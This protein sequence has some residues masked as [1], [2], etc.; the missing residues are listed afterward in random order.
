M[1]KLWRHKNGVWYVL[2]GPRLKRRI[3]TGSRSRSEA[4]TFFAQF[5]AGSQ[6]PALESPT[7]GQILKGYRDDHGRGL[8]GQDGLK[9]GVA[10]LDKRLGKLR[11]DHLTPTVIKRYALERGA[12]AGTI[13][14]EIGVLRA[15]LGWAERHKL[16][17]RRP[18]IL[19]PV[20]TPKPRER[21]LSKDEARRLIAACHDQHIRLFVVLALATCARSGAIIEAQWSQIDWGR[22][23]MDLGDGHGN[24]RRAVVPLN[25]EAFEALTDAKKL[26]CSP[27]I[28]E[29]HGRPIA[30]VKKGFAAACKRAGIVGATPHILRHTGASWMVGAGIPIAEVARMLGDSERTVER[31]YAKFS[32]N[33]LKNAANS[34]Q[35]G[36]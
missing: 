14:R 30:S 5:V 2:H 1:F 8:R 34:L 13:L 17:N 15:A 31:V 28:I 21:W 12:S 6:E 26:A 29:Y 33:Y 7:V 27:Y 10:A 36:S 3:S 16:I 19:N 18:E 11:P 22:K 24:K 23:V 9:Y 4:E 20:P 32:P 25:A 35:F